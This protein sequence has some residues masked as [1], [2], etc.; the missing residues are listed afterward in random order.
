MRRSKRSHSAYF[1]CRVAPPTT[2]IVR[3]LTA[4]RVVAKIINIRQHELMDAVVSAAAL[5]AQADGEIEPTERRQLLSFANRH[6]LLVTTTRAEILDA[7]EHRLR[8]L[9]RR[10]GRRDALQSVRRVAGRSLARLALNA[11]KSVA[12]ADGSLH[13]TER[14]VLQLIGT[15]L[16]RPVASWSL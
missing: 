4:D 9:Q 7:F 12:L 2:A 16:D 14:R 13:A 11:G 8:Q 6:G 5:V 10:D 15:V 1:A 3:V